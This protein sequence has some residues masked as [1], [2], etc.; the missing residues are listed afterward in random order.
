M[1][2]PPGIRPENVLKTCEDLIRIGNNDEALDM[3][4]S[5]V[6][7]KKFK[8]VASE[9]AKQVGYLFVQ[10]CV[11]KKDARVAKEGLYNFRKN[12][13]SIAGGIDAVGAVVKK[14]VQLAEAATESVETPSSG[15][16]QSPE[17]VLLSLMNEDDEVLRTGDP[18]VALRFMYEAYRAALDVSRNTVALEALYCMVAQRAF[19]FCAKHQRKFDF[20]RLNETIR[21]HL[22]SALALDLGAP[23][24]LDRFLGLRFQGLKTAMQMDLYHEAFRLVE[25]VDSQLKAL[26]R[27]PKPGM[28]LT[29][30][31]SLAKIFNVAGSTLF[32][33]AAWLKF[34]N[35]YSQSAAALESSLQAYASIIALSAMLVS[36][37]TADAARLAKLA[38][39]LHTSPAPT[40]ES[41]INAVGSAPFMRLVDADVASLFSLLRSEK[42][43][44]VLL[45]RAAPLLNALQQ[46]S[47]YKAFFQDVVG[48][49]ADQILVLVGS[50]YSNFDLALL[51]RLAGFAGSSYELLRAAVERKLLAL[52]RNGRVGKVTVDHLRGF[53]RFE[54]SDLIAGGALAQLC[55]VLQRAAQSAYHDDSA[56]KRK[57]RA[58]ARANAEI[59]A[60]VEEIERRRALL[61]ERER[62]EEEAAL[63]RIEEAKRAREEKIQAEKTAERERNAAEAA[64]RAEEKRKRDL[65]EI[66]MKEK[67]RVAEDINNAGIIK[68]DMDEIKDMKIEDLKRMQVEKLTKDQID[69]LEHV[70]GLFKR[71]DHL[72]RAFRKYEL[73]LLAAEAPKQKE[74]ALKN[75]NEMKEGIIKKAKAAHEEEVRLRDRLKRVLPVYSEFKAQI[76]ELNAEKLAAL[77]AEA[78]AKFEAERDQRIAF[79]KEKKL[80]EM[81]EEE[82]LKAERQKQ[83][84]ELKKREEEER[85]KQEEKEAQLLKLREELAAQRKADEE[86]LKRQQAQ[87]AEV[88][89]RLAAQ[90]SGAYKV[91]RGRTALY[92]GYTEKR[93][94]PAPRSVSGAWGALPPP[95]AAPIN[96]E[97]LTFAQKMK[98][99]R[100]GKL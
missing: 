3:L 66:R 97:K 34:F 77:K 46:N 69:T 5:F 45:V 55:N 16:D 6:G 90:R 71:A 62:A 43:P 38:G 86:L 57:E 61:E 15:E 29:Y 93:E 8:Y 18:A 70:K 95:A 60:E 13:Q 82:Q 72:E 36:P 54:S 23:A 89:R 7:L 4:R 50:A 78:K 40:R 91:P 9:P 2:P 67:L 27:A 74:E 79:L 28:M 30:Y 26:R 41:I 87:E 98:L 42:N 52:A 22:A 24:S 11:E 94:E 83:E 76:D 32:R 75:Y 85:K 37:T 35:L 31:E 14:Y 65:D 39:L 48:A 100:E 21:V 49:V 19:S 53:V 59:A 51:A 20:R 44:H 17:S 88:E 56:A 99:K 96:P 80:K 73:K 12:V 92:G 47:Q 63:A 58:L 64:R 81:I 33:S 84:E 25:D 68:I 1:A 10:L